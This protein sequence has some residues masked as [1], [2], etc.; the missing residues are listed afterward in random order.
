MCFLEKRFWGK[1]KG[2]TTFDGLTGA[3]QP[4]G[5]SR[6]VCID[7]VAFFS[8]RHWRRHPGEENK[9]PFLNTHPVLSVSSTGPIESSVMVMSES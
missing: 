8:E 5:I 9:A 4:A 2:V 6:F 7:G 1:L 3:P